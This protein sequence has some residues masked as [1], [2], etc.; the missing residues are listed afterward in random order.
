M[1]TETQKYR[2]LLLSA[3]LGRDI[4]EDEEN[5]NTIDRIIVVG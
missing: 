2:E 1:K 3:L 4:L 5:N